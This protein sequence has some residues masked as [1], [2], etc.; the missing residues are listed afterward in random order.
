MLT[1]I[2]TGLITLS[3]S[4][5]GLGGWAALAPLDGAVV[6]S[7]SLVVH[8]NRKTVAHRE[9]GIV[10]SLA[11]ADGDVVT[12]GQVLL[13]LD[14]AQARAALAV[15]QAALAGDMALVARDLAEIGGSATISFPA[16]LDGSDASA[17]SVM[18]RERT[19]FRNHVTLLHEQ[20]AVIDQ[21]IVQARRQREGAVAQYEAARTGLGLAEQ[22][23]RAFATLTQS[24]LAS[25]TRMLEL[26]RTVES[27]RGDAGQLQSEI[28][29][30][31]AEAAELTEEKLRLRAAAQADATHELREAQLRINDV[32]PRIA[33]DQDQ[34][35]RLE[36]RAPATGQVV[37]Q[38]VFTKG[39]IIEPGKPILD[40]VPARQA[41]IADTEIRPEDIEYLHVGQRARVVVTGFNPRVTQAMDGR[42]DIISADRVN[43]ARSG[44]TYY[45][46]SVT[47]LND[48]EGGG[49][50][51]RLEPGMP[52]EVIVPVKPRTALDYLVEPLR[53][54][55]RHAGN[56]V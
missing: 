12:Q 52:V 9:G 39:G 44:R 30:H 38:T 20:L 22:E 5:G 33:A 56:E 16:G 18:E 48:Q 53:S 28:A 27:L 8:G 46:V 31:E 15:H 36:I 41:L 26:A 23:L 43:D 35:R 45:K 3:V 29:R 50:L 25:R 21:R 55:W 4:F 19:V 2:R 32:L 34:L 11:V 13:T 24:G 40:I 14:G 51:R 17:A 49:L 10:A 47:L 37:D 7:G 54:S 42:V 1:A 6:G